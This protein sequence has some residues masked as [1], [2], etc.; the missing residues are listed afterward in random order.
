MFLRLLHFSQ[1]HSEVEAKEIPPAQTDK[2][3]E[4]FG[5]F[6][7]ISL[8]ESLGPFY[9]FFSEMKYRSSLAPSSPDFS[10]S[11][12]MSAS[13]TSFTHIARY[14]P[15]GLAGFFRAI[16]LPVC[17]RISPVQLSTGEHEIK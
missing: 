7:C 3:S 2:T 1:V 8:S 14:P 12:A 10:S 11:D 16:C 17:A 13:S 4:E 9:S 5:A 6:R 15:V